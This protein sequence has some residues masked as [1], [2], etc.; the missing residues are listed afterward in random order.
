MLTRA[1]VATAVNLKAALPEAAYVNDR[2]RRSTTNQLTPQEAPP[3]LSS[4]LLVGP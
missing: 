1:K 2:L 4:G 3:Y